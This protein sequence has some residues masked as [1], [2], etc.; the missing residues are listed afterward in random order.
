MPV[1]IGV[2]LSPWGGYWQRDKRIASS[3]SEGYELQGE[4]EDVVFSF[5]GDKYYNRFREVC[6]D[7]IHNFKVI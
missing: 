2:W 1:N 5:R 7:M 3:R 4:G 6:L